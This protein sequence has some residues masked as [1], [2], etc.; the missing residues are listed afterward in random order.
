MVLV[1]LTQAAFL[2]YPFKANFDVR[3]ARYTFEDL[4]TF[5]INTIN[6][7]TK[8]FDSL[9]VRIYFRAREGLEKDL[10]VLLNHCIV[11]NPD[12][13]R[14]TL[15]NQQLLTLFNYFPEKIENTFRTSDS[16]YNYLLR[17]P[18]TG[19]NLKPLARFK[20]DVQFVKRDQT[21]DKYEPVL[22][23]AHRISNSDWTFSPHKK[24]DGD[25]ID[26]SGIDSIDKSDIDNTFWTCPINYYLTIHR[27]SEL[28]WGLP[29]DWELYYD[30]SKFIPTDTRPKQDPMPYADIAVP[31]NEFEEQ[32]VRDSA[33]LIISPLR[34]NQA[35]YRPDDKKYF[36][37]ITSTA[38]SFSVV[39]TATGMA[40]AS[41][42]FRNTGKSNSAQIKIKASNNSLL[43]TGGDTK[44][45]LTSNVYSGTIY[46]GEITFLP[47]GRYRIVAGADTSAPFIIKANVYNMVKDALLKFYGVNRC[48]DS[49]SW[50]HKPCHL[51]DAVTGGWHDCG[52][53]LKEG[54]T[55]SYTAAV[56]GL[57]SAAFSSVDKDRYDADQ[58]KTLT[59]DGIPDIL[60]EAKHGADFILRSYELAGGD[61]SKM[62]TSVGGFGNTGCGDDHNWW[63]PPEYQ[64]L[65]PSSRGGPP[66]CPRSEPTTDY[67]GKYAA[68]LAFVSKG[69]QRFDEQYSS[70]CLAAA[71]AIYSFTSTKLNSTSTPAYS[72][73]TIV[74]DDA[75]F[76][77]LA[78]LWAT[79]ERKY[80]DD[81]CYDKT[82][83]EKAST[84]FPKL[85]Q[86]GLFTNHEPAFSH[87]AANTDWASVHTHVLWGFYRLILNDQELCNK[88][89][90]TDRERL[91]LIEK[92]MVNLTANLCSVALGTQTITLPDGVLWV[93]SM[94][95]YDLP[96]FTMHTQMEWVW[97]RF[98]AGNITDMYYY[99]DI[100][101]RIQGMQ[102]PNTPA[103]TNWKANDVKNVLV[104][105]FDYQLGV[106]PW[107]ISMIYGIGSKNFNHPH[108][109]ASNPEQRNCNLDYPYRHLVGSLQGGYLPTAT[110]YDEHAN[111]YFH[112]EVGIDGTTNILMP[113][114][115]LCVAEGNV[116]NRYVFKSF[117]PGSRVQISQN[118]INSSILVKST[119]PLMSVALY[120]I[121]G[122][123]I[124]KVPVNISTPNSLLL[125]H[126]A[127]SGMYVVKVECADGTSVTRTLTRMQ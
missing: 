58:S 70:K 29:P 73:A 88:L 4:Y 63:G 19:I 115:G 113:A 104:R 87:S 41:G 94:L 66:R 49:K 32:L 60:Y 12:G 64:D 57:A 85:F 1:S 6:N 65:M 51:Q 16:T 122:R 97:N 80:L 44:Y 92:T 102:L 30:K 36:Y 18:L 8:P 7:D 55:M 127:V 107:D 25:P 124:Q 27:N 103:S 23:P 14:D 37:Y 105:M 42:T 15:F 39:N 59:T 52:D 71:R 48:G 17:L 67:L 112:S 91:G 125:R 46:E 72:G 77:C 61:V 100:A 47:E 10:A 114:L 69:M 108:H 68:N 50:F 126:T 53:H 79:G 82:L 11:L 106:N 21:F 3:T 43:V 2:T 96:W 109:R 111:D 20:L 75:A 86:G 34:V 95:K 84:D 56:L 110:V 26:F 83:G 45:T 101:S 33:N 123:Q 40:V 81:L 62:I 117:V 93:P 78:L 90:L 120:T 54:A 116:N 118:Q 35:G 38:S 9:E 74:T 99:Y 89:E 22:P 98:Q 76:G 28:L 119:K 13:F 5:S 24:M 121:G 31:F